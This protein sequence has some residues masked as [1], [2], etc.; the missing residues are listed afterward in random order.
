MALILAA[1]G[2]RPPKLGGY[3][4]QTFCKL[5]VFARTYLEAAKPDEVISGMAIGWDT[6]WAQAAVDLTIPFT[7]AVPFR[8][9]ARIWPPS[10]QDKYFALLKKAK[11]VEVISAQ[12]N[13]AAFQARNEWM[14]DNCH[15]LVA[16]W[17]GT[18][19]GTANCVAYAR[20][21]QRE[22]ENLWPQWIAL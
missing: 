17:D 11:H 10:T 14:V 6:A 1:T 22:T 7:A 21:V 8:G 12:P 16:L 18:S 20:Q 2:H 3:G 9:Q 4:E 13:D 19:G 15:K 5:V